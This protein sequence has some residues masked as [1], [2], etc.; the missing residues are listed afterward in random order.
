VVRVNDVA[1]GHTTKMRRNEAG[2]W[3]YSDEIVHPSLCSDELGYLSA[4]AGHTC[5]T[6]GPS[7]RA[8]TANLPTVAPLIAIQ[9]Q[10]RKP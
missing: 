2:A 9:Q 8:W 1:L 6:N 5:P 3:I 7:G 10:R 4:P